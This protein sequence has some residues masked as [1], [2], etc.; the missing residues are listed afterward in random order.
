MPLIKETEME[1]IINFIKNHKFKI[2]AVLAALIFMA[3]IGINA[4]AGFGNG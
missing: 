3:A 2:L 1:T 4:P